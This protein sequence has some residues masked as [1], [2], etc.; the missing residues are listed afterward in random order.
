MSNVCSLAE[1][2]R[3]RSREAYKY[4]LFPQQFVLQYYHLATQSRAGLRFEAPDKFF[5]LTYWNFHCTDIYRLH[6][7]PTS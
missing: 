6:R 2:V 5:P 1:H 7:G 3:D 4:V